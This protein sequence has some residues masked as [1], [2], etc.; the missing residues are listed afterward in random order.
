MAAQDS[1]M[2]TPV[3]PGRIE[4]RAHVTLTATLETR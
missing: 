2:A 3:A 4:L 1:A